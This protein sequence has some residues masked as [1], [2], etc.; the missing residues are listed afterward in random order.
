[1]KKTTTLLLTVALVFGLLAGCS[2][3]ETEPSATPAES[4]ISSEVPPSPS[5]EPNAL[6]ES[7]SK[8][9]TIGYS[10]PSLSVEFCA[11]TANA[12]QAK[13]D[14]LG[15]EFVISDASLDPS[16]QVSQC[17]NLI[18]SGVD[19]LLLF[20]I[21]TSA[22]APISEACE[23]AGVP[24]ITVTAPLETWS[25]GCVVSDMYTVGKMQAE[26]AIELLGTDFKCVILQGPPE[27]DIM[28]NLKDGANDTL[29]AAGVEV[30]DIQI[31]RN[32][33]DESMQAV[34][35]WINAGIEFDCLITSSDGS[36]VGAIAAFKD[37]AML[38]DVVIIS[39]NGDSDGINA[40][41]AGELDATI[42]LPATLYG[43]Y[44]I[45]LLVEALEGGEIAQINTLPMSWIDSS[46]IADYL[47]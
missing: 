8:N 32:L 18:N 40:V 21:S 7:E 42:Y 3:N 46:N 16:T 27:Q 15:I 41:A 5:E 12:A 14:E 44:G 2:A 13:C 33:V 35:N 28:I 6:I 11:N 25:T 39:E 26:K 9:Y 37:A 17:E 38:D 19:A 31:G 10:L 20:P 22:C 47:S 29:T 4:A 23:S 45:E 1:M 43:S 34:E 30:V 36:A 24:L